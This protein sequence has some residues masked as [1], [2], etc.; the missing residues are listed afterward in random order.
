MAQKKAN[1]KSKTTVRRIKANDDVAPKKPT[2][3]SQT[4]TTKATPAK[5]ATKKAAEKSPK[6]S[7]KS[8]NPFAAIGRYFKGSWE[9][10]KQVRWPNRA[11]TW[12]LTGAVLIF[13]AFF[14]TLILLLDAGF[15]WVFE[16]I[17]R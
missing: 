11:N 9:E 8:K 4:K 6:K 14:A 1:S 2:K 5:P 16:Q 7:G 17:L 13:T 3:K 15:N 10:L 12:Q